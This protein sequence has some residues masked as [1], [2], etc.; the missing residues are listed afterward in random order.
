LLLADSIFGAETYVTEIAPRERFA[1]CFS[2]LPSI[3][4]EIHSSLIADEPQLDRKI[5]REE[6][7]YYSTAMLWMRLVEV[8]AK[9]NEKAITKEEKEIHKAAADTEYNVPQPLLSYLGQIGS[10]TDAMGKETELEVPALPV[11]V[12]QGHGGYHAAEVNEHTHNLFE[13][14]PSLGIAADMVMALTQETSEPEV[15]FQKIYVDDFHLL[16]SDAQR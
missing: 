9:Q 11:T 16:V 15:N 2:R 5:T 13:E 7:A 12:F 14:V 4:A 1:T 3:A 10:Y 8:K 6:V